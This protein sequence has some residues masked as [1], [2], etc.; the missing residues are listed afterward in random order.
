LTLLPEVTLGEAPTP[1]LKATEGRSR[2][3]EVAVD[4]A[5]RGGDRTYTY[6]VPDALGDLELG[7]AVLVEFGRRQALGIIVAEASELPTGGA[8][9]IVDRVRADG[10][11]TTIYAKWFAAYGPVPSPP[12]AKYSD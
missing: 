5:G 4:A 11:W 7:E 8:K 1:G 9:P 10:T 12:P 6:L 2:A 3:V